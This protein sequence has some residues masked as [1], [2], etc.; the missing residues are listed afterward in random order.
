MKTTIELDNALVVELEQYAADH[1]TTLSAV[2][3]SGV[4][5]LLARDPESRA[6]QPTH[7]PAHGSGGLQPGVDLNDSA[8][9]WEMMDPGNAPH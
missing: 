3:E 9:L 6:M 2:I 5:T 4:R 1:G 8:S 7:L